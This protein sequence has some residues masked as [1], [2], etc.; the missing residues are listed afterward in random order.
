LPLAAVGA[1]ASVPEPSGSSIVMLALVYTFA[2]APMIAASLSLSPLRFLGGAILL[3]ALLNG[4][5][6][7]ALQITA[8]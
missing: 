5:H 1:Y 8:Y 6:L 7:L 4:M 2:C 3:T